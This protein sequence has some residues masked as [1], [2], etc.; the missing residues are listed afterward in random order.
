MQLLGFDS[1]ASAYFDR[2]PSTVFLS[3]TVQLKFYQHSH[4]TEDERKADVVHG[5]LLLLLTRNDI[6]VKEV[7]GFDSPRPHSGLLF[8]FLQFN[9]FNKFNLTYFERYTADV[10]HGV[11]LHS[12]RKNYYI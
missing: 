9:K 10:V 5:A 4:K 3:L 7:V 1:P 11:P 6:T 12:I 8:F 2:R